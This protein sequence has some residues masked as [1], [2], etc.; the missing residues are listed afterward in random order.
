MCTWRLYI[1]NTFH[2]KWRH[3]DIRN[4]RHKSKWRPKDRPINEMV[5]NMSHHYWA[6]D[7]HKNPTCMS[8]L[9]LMVD[10]YNSKIHGVNATSQIWKRRRNIT[11]DRSHLGKDVKVWIL[12]VREV[13][14]CMV[15]SV[16]D[17]T[18]SRVHRGLSQHMIP[19]NN[20]FQLPFKNLSML[21]QLS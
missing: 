9:S 18:Q 19:I 4:I 11:F 12:L 8:I 13:C 21:L 1:L 3:K 17:L 20:T 5:N 15:Q 16:D 7:V 2:L 6:M 10:K 14:A